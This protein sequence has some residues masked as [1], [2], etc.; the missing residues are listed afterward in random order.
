MST[1]RKPFIRIATQLLREPWTRDE[2]LTL[3]MLA[4][5]LGDRWA[6]DRLTAEEAC[7]ATLTRDQLHSITGRA[8]LVHGRRAL[9]ALGEHVSLAI[10]ERGEF[11]EILWS[12]YAEFQELPSRGRELQTRAR[13]IS[14][15]AHAPAP[16][17]PSERS[18]PGV[19][20]PPHDPAPP[21]A[22]FSLVPLE[23]SNAVAVSVDRLIRL[24][25]RFEGDLDTKRT[26]I[27][28]NLPLMICEVAALSGIETRQQAN[29]KLCTLVIRWWRQEL[30]NPGGNGHA[31]S[32]DQQRIA[33]GKA[34]L[35]SL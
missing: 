34:W 29:A 24:L 6:R 23:D 11:T 27:A 30:R 13:P 9:R 22:D 1:P 26:W 15:H 10:R 2:K 21:G 25:A 20:P 18:A 4:C 33:Q 14:A 17:N 3:V 19:S 28:D 5:F 16:A 32:F 35:E 12:K 7:R 8:Q 31:L